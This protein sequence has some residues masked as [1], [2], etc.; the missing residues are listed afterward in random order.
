M[1]AGSSRNLA[2][3]LLTRG[4]PIFH[5]AETAV[6]TATRHWDSVFASFTYLEYQ[7]L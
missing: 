4:R 6:G 7:T 1:V 5:K 3:I 2:P